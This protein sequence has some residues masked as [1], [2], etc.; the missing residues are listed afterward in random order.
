MSRRGQSITLSISEQDKA[1]LEALAL[2]FGLMWG[3]RPNVSKLLEAI[4][5]RELQ[6]AP[7]NN[8]SSFRIEALNLA[9]KALLD[10]SKTDEAYEI[11]W[12]LSDRSELSIP[13]RGE[14][15]RFLNNPLPPWRLEMNNLIHSQQPFRLSYRDPT[16]RFWHYTILHGQNILIDNQQYLACRC[17]ETVENQEIKEL[18]HNWMLKLDRIIEAAVVPLDRSW[19]S[20]LERVA[21][22]F[23]L[24]DRQAFAY[25]RQPED[26]FVSQLTGDPPSRQV[27][28]SIFNTVYFFQEISRYWEDC[29]IVSP[30]SVRDRFKEK[31]NALHQ[32]Y[33]AVTQ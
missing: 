25:E 3:D 21:V 30:A 13:F 28:R 14:I 5:R 26:S 9:V 29:V 19:L 32:R 11:A 20:D 12:M 10:S 23:K 24:Y 16:D 18:C 8:W 7:N 27:I 22:E 17:E 4:A 33:G 31:V 15:E 6:V 2:E 1:R